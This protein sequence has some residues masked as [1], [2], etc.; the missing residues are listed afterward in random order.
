MDNVIRHPDVRDIQALQNIWGTAFGS[1][2]APLFFNRYFKPESCITVYCGGIPASAG[3]YY[4]AGNLICNEKRTPCAMI[5]AVATL[6]EFRG[7]G[8]GAAVVEKLIAAARSAGYPIV[9]LCPSEDSLFEYYRARTEMKEYFYVAE[10]RVAAASDGIRHD[11]LIPVLADEY[12]RLR[13]GLLAGIPHIE[14]DL[15]ALL[16]QASLCGDNNGGMFRINSPGGVSITIVE[17][18]RTGA[19]QVKELLYRDGCGKDA[20]SA[21]I[22]AFPAQEYIVWTPARSADRTSPSDPV[23]APEIRRFGML[24]SPEYLTVDI[25]F[26]RPV[27]PGS[28]ASSPAS[29]LSLPWL[30]LAFD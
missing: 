17:E 27:P 28:R 12:S 14:P 30:G 26:Y 15:N 4:H 7:R 10:Q 20:L 25:D 18:G 22:T 21:I 11:G 9:A 1:D 8:F 13:T 6:P 3:Y 2:D 24:A 23:A 29:Q 5:Y 19:V 16:Y